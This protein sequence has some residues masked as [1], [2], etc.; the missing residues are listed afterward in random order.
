MLVCRF[1]TSRLTSNS[2]YLNG[3]GQL[4]K[5]FHI[6][7]FRYIHYYMQYI[8]SPTTSFDTRG[9]SVKSPR[10][11]L[12]KN[13]LKR[14]KFRIWKILILRSR[15]QEV[16]PALNTIYFLTYHFIW[17]RKWFGGKLSTRTFQKQYKKMK[18]M[19]MAN[20]NFNFARAVT[21]IQPISTGKK[22]Y[23]SIEFWQ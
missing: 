3:A 15:H 16:N 14:G 10:R 2:G 23:M 19:I 22:S 13:G 5:L 1:N 17:Y 18:F 9:G 8:L 4:I 11:D 21:S 7:M 12:S 20:L 6:W